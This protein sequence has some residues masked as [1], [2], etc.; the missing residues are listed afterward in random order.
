MSASS[1]YV[2]WGDDGALSPSGS[3]GAYSSYASSPADQADDFSAEGVFISTDELLTLK[4]WA[5]DRDLLSSRASEAEDEVARL[6]QR[7]ARSE[8]ALCAVLEKAHADE[9]TQ[10]ADDLAAVPPALETAH[11]A[12]SDAAPVPASAAREPLSELAA[13]PPPP[14]ARAEEHA[15][16]RL[17]DCSTLEQL[18]AALHG[19]GLPLGTRKRLELQFRAALAG[20][21]L[22]LTFSGETDGCEQTAC[23][24]TDAAAPAVLPSLATKKRTPLGIRAR[25][26]LHNTVAALP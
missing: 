6:R 20:W 10:L 16:Q 1:P 7:L 2:P 12:A 18:R 8:A 15:E 14:R 26:R 11:G 24:Q 21:T 22:S 5:E 17:R 13:E 19:L 9:T 23:E 4:Q 3:G 25:R